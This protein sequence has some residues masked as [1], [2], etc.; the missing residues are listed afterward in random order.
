[1][2]TGSVIV[3]LIVLF[4]FIGGFYLWRKRLRHPAFGQ[5]KKN[6][7]ET[8]RNTFPR[9]P[10]KPEWVKKEIIRLKAL[11]PNDGHRKIAYAFNR[12]Y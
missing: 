1:M 5:R 2:L 8:N 12:L 10:P 6:L 3:L 7:Q 9:H 4:I 11:M